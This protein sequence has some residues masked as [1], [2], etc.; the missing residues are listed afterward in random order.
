MVQKKGQPLNKPLG[1]R[2][3][4]AL[5]ALTVSGGAAVFLYSLAELRSNSEPQAAPTIIPN[6]PVIKGA[7]ALGRLEPQG[8]VIRLSAPTSTG[9]NRV[10]Q[11][12]IKE[13]DKVTKGQIVAIMETNERSQA[14]LNRA[15]AEV[16]VAKA[17]LERVK[18]GAKSGD[19]QARRE[20]IFR[21]QAELKGQIATQEATIA[22]IEAEVKNAEDENRRYQGLFRDGAIAR[23]EADT[24]RLRLETAQKQLQEAKET[25][26]RTIETLKIQEEQAKATLDSVK[27]VRPVD[28][29]VAQAELQSAMAAVKQA[30]AD[31][32]LTAIRSPINGQILDVNVREGEVVGTNGIADIGKTGQMYVVAEVYETDIKKVQIGQPAVI[33]SSVFEGELQGTVNQIGLKVDR[34]D[35]FEVNPQAD[36]DNKVIDV[37]IRLKPED[38]KKV[39][40]LTN[41][42]V[43]VLIKTINSSEQVKIPNSEHGLNGLH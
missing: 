14:A 11:L 19:I 15:K 32:K 30:E 40:N 26:N 21:L 16:K 22:R 34:Q 29:Q 4:P 37:K 24:R 31:Y 9:T 20:D 41:L 23:S 1:R 5:V 25:K 38:S 7:A 33:T 36:T 13:G 3:L 18:A 42:Q 28:V 8:E 27:E 39:A 43:Q 2:I 17:Q 35:I 10:T 6:K 12:V